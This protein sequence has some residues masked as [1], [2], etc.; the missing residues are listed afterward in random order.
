ALPFRSLDHQKLQGNGRAV[1]THEKTATSRC[2]R[3]NHAPRSI[4]SPLH[5]PA[6]PEIPV[7]TAHSCAN[8]SAFDFRAPA[9]ASAA[10]AGRF[11][12]GVR[13]AGVR[14]LRAFVYR[15]PISVAH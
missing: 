14:I 8:R 7:V 9:Q 2:I 15:S 12:Q 3:P 10:F 13:A 4:F 11:W 5:K 6:L 1:P